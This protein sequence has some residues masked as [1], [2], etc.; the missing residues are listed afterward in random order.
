MGRWRDGIFDCFTF[1]CCHAHCCWACWFQPCALG[2]VRTRMKLNPSA[3]IILAI[4]VLFV[5]HMVITWIL[6]F[7]RTREHP[8][9]NWRVDLVVVQYIILFGMVAILFIYAALTRAYIRRK[10]RIPEGRCGPCDDFCCSFWCGACSV[11][12]M[13]RHTADYARYPAACCTE[14]GLL[15]GAPEVV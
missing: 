9:Y 8:H 1:G 4:R 11:S 3:G 12:Q 14:T 15:D 7:L 6:I 10:Y 5:A 2:Q 13:A